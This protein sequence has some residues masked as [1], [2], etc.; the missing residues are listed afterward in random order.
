MSQHFRG[1]CHTIADETLIGQKVP[2]SDIAQ[3][4]KMQ[5]RVQHINFCVLKVTHFL[6][7]WVL[8]AS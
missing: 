6:R 2:E 4:A 5:K 7:F 3:W 1:L 8:K